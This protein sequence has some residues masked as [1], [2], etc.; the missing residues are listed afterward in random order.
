M[1]LQDKSGATV[2]PAVGQE[3]YHPYGGTDPDF[4]IPADCDR[5]GRGFSNWLRGL[6]VFGR[7]RST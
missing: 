5:R 3:L 6:P 1:D 7:T 4:H 2:F